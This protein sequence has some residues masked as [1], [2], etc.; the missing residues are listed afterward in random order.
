M[1]F[2]EGEKS[3]IWKVVACVL[4]IGNI[5]F[6]DSQLD[7]SFFLF[8][9]QKTKTKEK[10]VFL[11]IDTPCSIKNMEALK[12][13]SNLLEMPVEILSKALVY[14]TRIIQN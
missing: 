10:I 5:D 9:Q 14:K 7:N 8:F 12:L 11:Y 3:A 1:D 13:C 4:H 2:S 6:D